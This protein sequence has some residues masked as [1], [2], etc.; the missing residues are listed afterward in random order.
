MLKGLVF[1][2]L[3]FFAQNHPDSTAGAR[4]HGNGSAFMQHPNH[5]DGARHVFSLFWTRSAFKVRI[6]FFVAPL[7]TLT[8]ADDKPYNY[9]L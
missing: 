5:T 6:Q 7:S 2:P 8:D 9:L 1:E 4:E 3:P